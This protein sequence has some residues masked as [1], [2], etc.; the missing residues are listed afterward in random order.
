MGLVLVSWLP[1][2]QTIIWLKG[3][4]GDQADEI[5]AVI[6]T[7]QVLIGFVGVAIAGKETIAIAKSSGWRGLPRAVWTLLRSPAEHGESDGTT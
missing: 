7:I 2:A 4:S 6:W 3:A 5:R 1:F